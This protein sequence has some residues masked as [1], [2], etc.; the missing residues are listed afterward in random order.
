MIAPEGMVPASNVVYLACNASGPWPGYYDVLIISQPDKQGQFTSET[1]SNLDARKSVHASHRESA[2][3]LNSKKTMSMQ[4]KTQIQIKSKS[5]K[6]LQRQVQVNKRIRYL[7]ERMQLL[8]IVS[9]QTMWGKPRAF[10]L[11]PRTVTAK[12]QPLRQKQTPYGKTKTLT[13]K[14]KTSRQKQNTSRQNQILHGKS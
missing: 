13:P 12:P 1:N 10:L 4:R 14:T 5:V 9:R 3:N 7:Y 8:W 11:W 6:G 2:K